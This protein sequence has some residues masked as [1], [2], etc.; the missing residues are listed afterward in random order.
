MSC[1]TDKIPITTYYIKNKG[2]LD[3]D[4]VAGELDLP[5]DMRWVSGQE[6]LSQDWL[7]FFGE[8]VSLCQAHFPE[9]RLQWKEYELSEP[10]SPADPRNH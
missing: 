2:D 6:V 9:S 10:H 3:W 7:T 5:A 4:A 8:K 1:C